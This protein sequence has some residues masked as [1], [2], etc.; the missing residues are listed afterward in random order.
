MKRVPQPSIPHTVFH[1]P[2]VKVVTLQ[3]EVWVEDGQWYFN[4]Y[5]EDKHGNQ[6]EV[7]R[8]KV[9]SLRN[10]FNEA[11]DLAMTNGLV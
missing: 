9:I 6:F 11:R 7:P 4:L 2:S 3:C 10:I 8:D 1:I 5:G